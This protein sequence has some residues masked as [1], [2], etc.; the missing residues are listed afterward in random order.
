MAQIAITPHNDPGI[1][2]F[3]D[4]FRIDFG[5]EQLLVAPTTTTNRV[6]IIIIRHF[7]WMLFFLL[8]LVLFLFY[9]TPHNKS[10]NP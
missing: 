7:Y 1:D 4:W 9:F 5:V 3:V 2:H 8:L 10:W 6:A